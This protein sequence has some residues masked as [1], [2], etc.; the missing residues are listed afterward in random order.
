MLAWVE[1]THISLS[2]CRKDFLISFMTF[3]FVRMKESDPHKVLEWKHVAISNTFHARQRNS[4]C[5][6]M[7]VQEV[8]KWVGTERLNAPTS[9]LGRK[10]KNK[11]PICCPGILQQKYIQTQKQKETQRRRQNLT[12]KRETHFT[13]SKTRQNY[14]ENNILT[15]KRKHRKTTYQAKRRQQQLRPFLDQWKTHVIHVWFECLKLVTYFTQNHEKILRR[16]FYWHR[17]GD[18]DIN[19]NG[20][21][22]LLF[23]KT[24]VYTTRIVTF[25]KESKH[26][27]GQKKFTIQRALWFDDVHGEKSIQAEIKLQPP[28]VL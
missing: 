24:Q 19:F 22:C 21:M 12:P 4:A 1:G 17:L 14:N 6:C 9:F 20:K 16:L 28:Y 18:N 13:Y 23:R 8:D 15:T 11:N 10:K 7:W 26:K 25:S 3:T 5:M 2:S 27:L